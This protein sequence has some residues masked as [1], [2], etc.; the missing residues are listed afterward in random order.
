MPKLFHSTTDYMKQH[1][2]DGLSPAATEASVEVP[3][4]EGRAGGN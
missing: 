2:P 3:I 4:A 1:I